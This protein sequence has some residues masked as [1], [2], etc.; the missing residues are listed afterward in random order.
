MI[1]PAGIIHGFTFF[2]IVIEAGTAPLG[3]PFVLLLPLVVLI[4]GR[5]K[6]KSQPLLSFYFISCLVAIL[7]FAG[8]GIYW[9]G[10]PEFSEIGII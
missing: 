7:F 8:W 9:S 3:I 1:I 5:D 4:W 2:L 6:L 10:L